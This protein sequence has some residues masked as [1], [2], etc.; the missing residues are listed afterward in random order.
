M[1]IRVP[2]RELKQNNKSPQARRIPGS[3]GSEVNGVVYQLVDVGIP[4]T[5]ITVSEYPGSSHWELNEQE[6]SCSSI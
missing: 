4:C 1:S 5:P 6:A 3:G 2:F